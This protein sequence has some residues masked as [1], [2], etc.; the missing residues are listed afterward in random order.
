MGIIEY[1]KQLTLLNLVALTKQLK[2][3]YTD[4]I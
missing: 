3:I 4:I 1:F 2:F